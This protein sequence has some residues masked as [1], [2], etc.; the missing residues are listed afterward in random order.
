[1][2][3]VPSA[4]EPDTSSSAGYQPDASVQTPDATNVIDTSNT[5]SPTTMTTPLPS[6]ANVVTSTTPLEA[7]PAPMAA[8]PKKKTRT[9]L[10]VILAVLIL[11]VA[12]L[13]IY[14]S[15]MS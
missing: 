8:A 13:I 6:D 1:M 7:M 4:H 5:S 2:N 10:I 14:V 15:T 9:A 3:D 12:G 11:A